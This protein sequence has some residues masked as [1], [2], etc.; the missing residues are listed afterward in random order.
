MGHYAKVENNIVT[1]VIVAKYDYIQSR[2]DSEKWIKTSYNTHGGMHFANGNGYEIDD[3]KPEIRKNFAG[4]GYTYDAEADAFYRPQPYPSWILN[5][6]TYLWE[7]AIP[8]PDDG[9]LYEWN[10][11]NQT[12]D[13]AE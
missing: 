1:E 3:S 5:T 9:Q 7:S 6:E 11:E 13:L 12:W 2:E 8:Y 4:I 10:E